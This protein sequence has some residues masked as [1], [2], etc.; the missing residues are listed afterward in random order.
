M[1]INEHVKI[2]WG[3]EKFFLSTTK[4]YNFIFKDFP[5]FVKYNN[6][7]YNTK[8]FI[9]ES[10]LNNRFFFK[11]NLKDFS[12]FFSSLIQ[13][14]L[15][16]QF[17]RKWKNI[18]FFLR[19]DILF[20]F[21]FINKNKL[22]NIFNIIFGDLEFWQEIDKMFEEGLICLS[23]DFIYERKN[24]VSISFLSILLLEIYFFELDLFVFNLYF[25]FSSLC[26]LFFR[27]LT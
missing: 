27:K 20:F 25:Q 4:F 16:L 24:F 23:G 11:D 10:C 15:R 21:K 26:D 14:S 1:F 22:K 5:Y 2:Y 8:G 19:L 12:F 6:Y 7:I 18:N 9:F 3:L 17:I 13:T